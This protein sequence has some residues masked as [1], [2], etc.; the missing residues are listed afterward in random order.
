M[1][2]SDGGGISIFNWS[3]P[4]IS[5][6][7]V[8][9]NRARGNNDGGGIFV[10]YWSSAKVRD[11]VIVANV[12]GDDGGG[13]FVGGQEHR[14]DRP[15]D[16]M[17]APED[18]FVEVTGNRFFG[19]TNPSG[20]SGATAHHDG[21]PRPGRRQ[22]RR[23]QPRLLPAAER[24]GGRPTTRS[25]KTP[26]SSRPRRASSPLFFSNNIVTGLAGERRHSDHAP[27]LWSA[28][29]SAGEGNAAGLP[30]FLEDG[31]EPQ[32]LGTS[33]SASSHQTRVDRLSTRFPP[34]DLANRVVASQRRRLG[35]RSL[36]LRP[37]PDP[38]G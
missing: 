25:S 36:R 2:S 16:P 4:E 11:N 15:F 28:T 34:D 9:G 17:P 38:L 33:Y 5:G 22:P 30:E 3:S 6:N 23:A 12:G 29:A 26:C 1:R 7:V 13:L 19:N 21:E 31:R 32:V 10:A 35:R 18:F 20:N 37:R 24:T 27:R 14:Y 8:L